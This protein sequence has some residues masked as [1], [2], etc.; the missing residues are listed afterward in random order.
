MHRLWRGLGEIPRFRYRIR[1]FAQFDAVRRFQP[2]R[3]AHAGSEGLPLRRRASC[4][5]MAPNASLVPQG[6]HARE[7]RG[8]CMVS[9]EGSCA[10]Y[11]RYY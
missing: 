7:P 10:A 8:P 5:I 3:R 9:S 11:H 1:E 6:M 2:D 4:G